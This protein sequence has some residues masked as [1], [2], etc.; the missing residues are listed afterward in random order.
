MT[1]K[2]E[3]TEPAALEEL[4]VSNTIQ[5]DALR[6]VL[7]AKGLLTSDEFEAALQKVQDEYRRQAGD[8]S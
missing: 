6:Q 2:T 1:A 5:L 4:V 3:T 7:I 8:A